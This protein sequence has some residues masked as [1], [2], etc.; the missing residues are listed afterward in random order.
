MIPKRRHGEQGATLV[1]ALAFLM[2]FGLIIAVLLTQEQASLRTTPVVDSHTKNLYASDGGI[3]YGIQRLR[4]D[5]SSSNSLC[6]HTD[7]DNVY[8]VGSVNVNG[9]D[10]TVTCQTIAGDASPT[11]GGVSSTGYS[12]VATGRGTF[13]YVGGHG[14]D[15]NK[16]VPDATDL[17]STIQ[18]YLCPSASPSQEVT[19][20]G[21]AIVNAGG[22]KVP[23]S[24]KVKV[25][26]SVKQF[27]H[28]DTNFCTRDK[29]TANYPTNDR[30]LVVTG[31]WSCIN[32][33]APTLAS[34]GADPAPS[35]AVPSAPLNPTTQSAQCNDGTTVTIMYPGKYTTKPSALGNS[36]VYLSSGVYYFASSGNTAIKAQALFGGEA[37]PSDYAIP[38][39]KTWGNFANYPGNCARTLTDAAMAAG[40]ANLVSASANWNSFDTG[41][42]VKGQGIPDGTTVQAVTPG[43]PRTVSSVVTKMGQAVITAPNAGAFSQADV[44]STIAGSGGMNPIPNGTTIV[45]VDPSADGKSATM[46][47][48]ATSAKTLSVTIT[49]KPTVT[50]SAPATATAGNV[51]VE[52]LDAFNDIVAKNKCGSCVAQ[53]PGKGVTFVVGGS[54]VFD[55]EQPGPGQQGT[56]EIY[57]RVPGT[58]DAGADHGTTLYAM[59]DA[60]LASAIPNYEKH[61]GCCDDKGK[62]NDRCNCAFVTD[63]AN[64]NI[65]FHG[66]TY[67]P[68][69]P[70]DVF[71]NAGVDYSPFY[72]G[73]VASWV[74]IRLESTSNSGLFA[75]QFLANVPQPTD[76]TVVV[77]AKAPGVNGV[78]NSTSTAVVVIHVDGRP[79]TINSWRNEQ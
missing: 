40:S 46:S 41:A 29:Q 4:N 57:S 33:P 44:G 34:L 14:G 28:A 18:L 60:T 52:V 5:G 15:C 66:L 64:Q 47:K 69:S 54:T 70:V 6:P 11:S 7:L 74:V 12:V 73:V 25:P 50:M 1:L 21:S 58:L 16:N 32:D 77:T 19:L 68:D 63:Q 55:I 9:Q 56:T 48:A 75:G 37:S 27:N 61:T 24:N 76:R 22:F 3:E 51:T 20:G 35:I 17:G 2:L 23:A 78:G 45:A 43:T 79:P 8:P 39:T 67:T 31:A 49:P 42:R 36:N 72:G 26:G 13:T 62:M 38:G 30:S 71:S 65:I 53:D 10:V 59:A